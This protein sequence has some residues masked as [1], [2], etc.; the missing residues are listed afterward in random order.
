MEILFA[1][2]SLIQTGVRPADHTLAFYSITDHLSLPL[3]TN[4]EVC[5]N[6]SFSMLWPQ[7]SVKA[8]QTMTCNHLARLKRL[9][10]FRVPQQKER[11]DFYS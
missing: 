6:T 1:F 5:R 4:T 2:L 9:H 8:G 7:F 3:T 10:V 11:W